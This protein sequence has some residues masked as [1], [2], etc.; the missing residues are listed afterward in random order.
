[1][2]E[3]FFINTNKSFPSIYVFLVFKNPFQV[4]IKYL[5]VFI[6]SFIVLINGAPDDIINDL[7]IPEFDL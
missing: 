6:N 2:F 5:L 1:M 4:F 3:C 7:Q